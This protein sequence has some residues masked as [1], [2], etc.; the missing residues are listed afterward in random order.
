MSADIC[1]AVF[2]KMAT[3]GERFMPGMPHSLKA[4]Y[5]REA[6]G[7]YRALPVGRGHNGLHLDRGAEAGRGR[8]RG[9]GRAA[10]LPAI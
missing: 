3:E 1:K 9:G 8:W 10:Y 5:L 7:R 4:A 2:C 6:L